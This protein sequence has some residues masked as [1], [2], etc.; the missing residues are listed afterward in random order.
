[1]Y[2][3]FVVAYQIYMH[4]VVAYQMYMHFVVAYQM[5]T[6]RDIWFI[7]TDLFT[8]IIDTIIAIS[9]LTLLFQRFTCIT[10]TDCP[11][12]KLICVCSP[13]RVHTL[14][15]YLTLLYFILSH[16]LFIYQEFYFVQ[17]L[18]Y[19]TRRSVKRSYSAPIST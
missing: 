11:C 19:H 9:F 2:M 15:S 18:N 7:C 10:Y 14:F 3:H 8:C 17:S 16:I 13:T 1:M 5:Y 12:S 4:I 6:Q